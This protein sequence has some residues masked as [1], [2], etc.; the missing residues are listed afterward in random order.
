MFFDYSVS[1][2]VT[3]LVSGIVRPRDEHNAE[4]LKRVDTWLRV[5]DILA[6]ESERPDLLEQKK[7]ISQMRGWTVQKI[8]AAFD[9][10][11]YSLADLPPCMHERH[12]VAGVDEELFIDEQWLP[13]FTSDVHADIFPLPMVAREVWEPWSTTVQSGVC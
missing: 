12:D 8:R 11:R 13:D 9:P 3:L 2:M 4:D 5:V 10:D 7:F 1:A 6:T